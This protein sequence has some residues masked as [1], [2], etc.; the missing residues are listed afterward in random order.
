MKH[1]VF[2]L[3]MLVGCTKAGSESPPASASASPPAATARPTSTGTTADWKTCKVDQDCTLIEIECCDHCNG[4]TLISVAT[5]HAAAATA[6]YKATGCSGE[7]TERGCDGQ[8]TPICQAGVCGY[9]TNGS[10]SRDVVEPL[11]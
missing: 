7:C 8:P 10:R 2:V 4:G 6:R 5:V 3:L 11:P 1:I 9:R